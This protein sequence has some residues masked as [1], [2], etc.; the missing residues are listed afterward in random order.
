MT[1]GI[2]LNQSTTYSTNTVLYSVDPGEAAHD[3][4]PH[5]DLHCL[6]CSLCIINMI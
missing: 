4:P 6:P 1:A 5:V 3:E 2:F